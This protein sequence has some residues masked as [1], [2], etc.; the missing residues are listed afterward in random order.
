MSAPDKH[1]QGCVHGTDEA[2]QRAMKRNAARDALKKCRKSVAPWLIPRL[3]WIGTPFL[4]AQGVLIITTA[5]QNANG[6]NPPTAW[7]GAGLLI[8]GP[9]ALRITCELVSAHFEIHTRLK[10]LVNR[11]G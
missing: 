2:I 9:I 7:A 1:G 3:F 4:M 6:A 5:F 11:D 8:L 10:E